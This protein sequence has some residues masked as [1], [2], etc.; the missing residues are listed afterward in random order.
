MARSSCETKTMTRQRPDRPAR[1]DVRSYDPDTGQ[2][3]SLD[4]RST[5]L[6]PQFMTPVIVMTEP[7]PVRRGRGRRRLASFVMAEPDVATF[8]QVQCALALTA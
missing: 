6:S 1:V 8:T 5:A 4:P 7:D 2:P 3:V